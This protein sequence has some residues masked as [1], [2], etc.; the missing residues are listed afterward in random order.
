MCYV[1]CFVVYTCIYPFSDSKSIYICEPTM[2]KVQPLMLRKKEP[3]TKRQYS[4]VYLI[5]VANNGINT[6]EI[7]KLTLKI[8]NMF[9]C[10]SSS[11]QNQC[12]IWVGCYKMV[13]W[14]QLLLTFFRIRFGFVIL[15]FWCFKWGFLFRYLS[16]PEVD[17][18]WVHLF[19][20]LVKDWTSSNIIASKSSRLGP[21]PIG[22]MSS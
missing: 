12:T 8:S 7:D 21:K 14:N 11:F 20:G 10:W 2:M 18:F 22:L 13:F 1:L 17:I 19:V 9:L 5:C 6:S 4:F 16:C 15:C 3:L